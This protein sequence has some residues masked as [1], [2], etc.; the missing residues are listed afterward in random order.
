M[1]KLKF[2]TAKN[3][4]NYNSPEVMDLLMKQNNQLNKIHFIAT[5]TILL[6]GIVCLGAVL[7]RG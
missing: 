7:L 6:F 2:M 4:E 3:K 5:M 1:E